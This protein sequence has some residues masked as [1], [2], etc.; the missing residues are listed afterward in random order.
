MPPRAMLDAVERL[1]EDADD[2]VGAARLGE[3]AGS[4]RPPP[5]GTGLAVRRALVGLHC[6]TCTAGGGLAPLIQPG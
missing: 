3:G 1:A 4:A 6:G 2:L 5:R